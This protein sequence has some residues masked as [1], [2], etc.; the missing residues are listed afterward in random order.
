VHAPRS[1]IAEIENAI[2]S[3]SSERRVETLRRVTDLFMLSA[4]SYSE[5]QVDV[6]DDVILRL[7]DKIESRARAELANRLAPVKNAPTTVVRTLASDDSIEVAGPVLTQSARLTDDDL[8]ACVAGKGQDRLLAISR[9]ASL[10]ERVS[11]ILVTHGDGD[12]V[13]S[14]AKNEGA[15]F[16]HSGFDKLVERSARDD[17]L[18]VSVGL[19]RDISKEHFHALV[20]KA[21]ETVFKKLAAAN[22]AAAAEVNRVLYDLTG[23]STVAKPKPRNKFDYSVAQQAFE[24]AQRADQP[25]DSVVRDYAKSGKFEET[26]VALATL[27]AL[28][29][30]VVENLMLDKKIDNDLVLILVKGSGLSWQT[31]KLILQLRAGETGVSPPALEKALQHFERLQIATAKRVLRFYQVRQAAGGEKA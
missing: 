31:A 11:D 21:S 5:E 8:V 28:S 24:L 13:R 22:P 17:E 15:R 3:G 25:L 27:C 19:R 26:V 6:F 14:V 12:V 1:L 20:S 18:A 16:S 9:R 4:D 2:S 10:S 7:A 29:I 30:D 23:V